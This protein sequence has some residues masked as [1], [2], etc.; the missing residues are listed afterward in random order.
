MN[1]KSIGIWQILS[2]EIIT[3]I[4]GC[5]NFNFV[6]FD[7]E[8]GLHDPISVQRCTYV[9]K[10]LDLI[11][12]ARVPSINYIDTVKL[13]DTG[14][15]GLIIP[16]VESLQDI[17]KI[18]NSFLSKEK[19]GD[20]SF[21]PFVPRFDFSK[22]ESK[23]INPKIGILIESNLGVQNAFELISDDVVD[24]VYFGAYDLSIEN[25][26]SG[27]IFNHKILEKLKCVTNYAKEN[28]KNVMAICRNKDELKILNKYGVNCPV[29][30][31][32]TALLKN[33][34]SDFYEIFKEIQ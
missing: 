29:F 31:V 25:N 16:H 6:I 17:N 10:S 13:V 5:S 7:L 26:I 14:I 2:S 30:T 20:R 23:N 3:N 8:H 4:I 28:N 34:L 32:D 19:D 18:K 11:S 21:S 27:E 15:N 33:S 1:D 22:I 24:F 12:F 9:A